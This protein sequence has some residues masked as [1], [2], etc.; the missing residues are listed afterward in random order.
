MTRREYAAAS[1]VVAVVLVDWL[2]TGVAAFDIVRFLAYDIGFVAL[3]GVAL[4][5]AIRGRRSSPLVAVALGWPL[6]QTLEIIAFSG[7]AE[8]GMR[9]LYL[10]YPIAVIV[11]SALVI[12]RRLG[13]VEHQP[14]SDRLSN[15]AL[16]SAAGV[17]SVGITY[18]TFMFLPLAPLPG[19][20]VIY[21]YP[22]YAYFFSLIAQVK[23]HW[24]PTTPGLAGVPLAYEWFVLFHMAAASQ[25]THLSIPIIGL[26]LDY[27]PSVV[28]VGCQ[29]LAVGRYIGRRVWT[30]VIA[31]ALMFLFG[32]L[33]LTTAWGP[34]GDNVLVHFFDSWTFPFGLMFF[35]A[36]V[37]LITE[38]MR[39]ETWRTRQDMRSWALIA[40]LMIGASG[41]KATLLPVLIA[42][43]GLFAVLHLI[44]R[45][46]LP[47][48]AVLTV[49]M[50]IVIFVPTYV[51]IY[52]GG[53]PDTKIEALQWLAG[54]PPVLF[55]NLIHHSYLRDIIL[56]FAYVADFGAVM[57][58]LVGM[59]YMLRHR[60]RARAWVFALP[61]CM[62]V[63]GMLIA[64]VVHH[65]SY[66]ELY[67]VDT[68]YVAGCFIGAEGLRLAWLDL[69]ELPVSRRAV[70]ISFAAWIV[71]L[72]L[73]VKLTTNSVSTPQ[74]VVYRCAEI[75]VAAL[76][77]LIVWAFALRAQ[78]RP[79]T[80]L[81]ALALVPVLATSAITT[82]II[83]YPKVRST[84]AGQSIN[85]AMIVVAPGL[86]TALYWLRDHTSSD[87]VFAVNN[88]WVDTT[89]TSGKFYLYTAFSERQA[90]IEAY[91]PYPIPVGTGTKAGAQFVYRQTLNDSVFERAD[92]AAL[93]IMIQQYGVR[94][95]LID[96]TLGPDDPA[97]LGL[98]RVV[99]SNPDADLLAVG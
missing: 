91:N 71:A 15:L 56:P 87:A 17:L 53:T 96:R 10:L 14:D 58:P 90:F 79:Y 75:T 76:I 5:W 92:S 95:L 37:Y 62:F 41:A 89:R 80:A 20:E 61:T 67:F 46:R 84:L 36:L 40:L 42:G 81:T 86:L 63:A 85:S 52:G 35:L 30:G 2:L 29:L 28:V 3:P 68:G 12:W 7:T 49:V 45:R 44:R 78:R 9:G 54:T 51:I 6:G 33:N 32:P 31:M 99:L 77:F 47:M 11:P 97:V 48:T 16:W 34:F 21:L 4:L 27:I 8:I 18:L 88:H 65:I 25:V 72:L 69:G 1:L 23:M 24:P 22:D 83:I 38:R 66:S 60:H 93:Q 94:F 64:S 26:R 74:Q 82:P 39:A 19:T 50:G 73:F 43:T 57:L 98:G 13:S 59:L 55:A 70:L